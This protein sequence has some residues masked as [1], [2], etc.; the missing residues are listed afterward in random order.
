MSAA[1]T[2]GVVGIEYFSVLFFNIYQNKTASFLRYLLYFKF[3][4]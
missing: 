4:K 3:K 1:V 2:G